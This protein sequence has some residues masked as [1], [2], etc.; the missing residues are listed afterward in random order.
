[1]TFKEYI[2]N[3]RLKRG[4]THDE[5]AKK[6]KMHRNSV[7]NAESG[8]PMKI[9]TVR[10][11]VMAMGCPEEFPTVAMLWLQERSG[12][13]LSG[14]GTIEWMDKAVKSL[15][16]G[17]SGVELEYWTWDDSSPGFDDTKTVTADTLAEA[18]AKAR[19]NPK[20]YPRPSR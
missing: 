17:D 9:D 14:Q 2:R 5:I 6:A 19:K 7:I 8:R 18:I 4:L 3:L 15:R 1:M 11:I 13:D 20:A 10:D 16:I 12:L